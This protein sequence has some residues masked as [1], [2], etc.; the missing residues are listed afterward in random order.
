MLSKN[1][2]L[3]DDMLVHPGHEVPLANSHP[4][5]KEETVTVIY[6]HEGDEFM[7]KRQRILHVF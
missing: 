4:L 3:T 2:S 1:N 6:D 5:K 7:H